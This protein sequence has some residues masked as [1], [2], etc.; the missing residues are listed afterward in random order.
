MVSAGF[1]DG[2]E[3]DMDVGENTTAGNGGSTHKFVE[4]IVVSD[5]E[6][7]VSGG[8]SWLL[9]FFSGVSCKFENLSGEVFKDGSEVDGGTGSNS[10][11]ES[12]CLEVT[13]DSSDGELE[14]SSG[15]SW[16]GF[17]GSCLTFSFSSC[18]GHLVIVSS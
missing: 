13:A 5:G 7:D 17:G 11:G 14:S 6:L 16:Y 9:V 4:L 3:S 18:S 2:E 15:W 8:D 10:L 1:F 12:S